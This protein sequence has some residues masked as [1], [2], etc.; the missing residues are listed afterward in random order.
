M[1]NWMTYTC[2]AVERRNITH[3]NITIWCR[4]DK[5][6]FFKGREQFSK[7]QDTWKASPL[8]CFQNDLPFDT[9][10]KVSWEHPV[11]S[12]TNIPRIYN[13]PEICY[14]IE[15]CIYDLS[16]L[17]NSLFS[18]EKYDDEIHAL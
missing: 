10:K 4:M 6:Y 8:I 5:M 15:N 3:I 9:A 14:I 12:R 11:H 1:G 18:T 2:R 17:F 7:E 16:L 13:F